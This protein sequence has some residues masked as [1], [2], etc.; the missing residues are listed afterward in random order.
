M[1]I[2]YSTNRE[3][4]GCF[5]VKIVGANVENLVI[6]PVIGEQGKMM[7]DLMVDKTYPKVETKGEGWQN[8]KVLVQIQRYLFI[9]IAWQII[10][11]ISSH[12]GPP[13]SSGS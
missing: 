5:C 2:S 10:I 4:C 9:Q 1:E 6:L 13:E 11:L 3:N 8:K 12:F 7:E